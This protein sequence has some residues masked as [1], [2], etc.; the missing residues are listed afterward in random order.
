MKQ[1]YSFIQ[2]SQTVID[3]MGY[4]ATFHDAVIDDLSLDLPRKITI[5]LRYSD[6]KE[7]STDGVE[8]RRTCKLV[9]EEVSSAILRFQERWLCDSEFECEPDGWIVTSIG[10]CDGGDIIILSHRVSVVD[11]ETDGEAPNSNTV[12]LPFPF[13]ISF[14]V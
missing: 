1:D 2:G 3:D 10:M 6:L 7:P 13:D 5:A 8:V 14:S 11:W 9:F 12:S 4:F